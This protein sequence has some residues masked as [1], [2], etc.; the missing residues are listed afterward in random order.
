[1]FTKGCLNIALKTLAV[2]AIFLD[3]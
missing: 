3:E 1:M 2:Y